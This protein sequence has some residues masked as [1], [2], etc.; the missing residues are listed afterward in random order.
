MRTSFRILDGQKL[1]QVQ[2]RY[3][4][5]CDAA[6]ILREVASHL[7]LENLQG[8]IE[9]VTTQCDVDDENMFIISIILS[10]THH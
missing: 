3:P 4:S 6:S 2:L 10:L 8:I 1:L 9:S 7:E 5:S